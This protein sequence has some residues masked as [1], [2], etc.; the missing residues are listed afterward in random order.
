LEGFLVNNTIDITPSTRVLRM[1]G[2][3]DFAPWQCLAELIDNSIDSFIDQKNNGYFSSNPRVKI[4]LPTENELKQD[5]GVIEVSDNGS[6]MTLTELESSVRA[7]YSGNDPVDKMGLFGMGFNIST[8]RLGRKTEVWTTK[9]DAEEWVGLIIDFD[10]LEKG[11]SFHAPV[12]TKKKS[13][14]EMDT[15]TNGTRIKISRLEKERIR[16]LI[17]GQ[18]KS[19]TKKRLGKI[20]GRVM[21]TLDISISYDGDKIVPGRHCTWDPKRT[22]P[23]EKFGDVPARIDIC[24]DFPDR[25]F[26][27]TCWVWLTESEANCSSCGLKNNIIDRKRTL[28]GWIGVQRYFHKK[29]FGIDLIRNGRV[30]EELDKSLFT[31][32]D[33][34]G[35]EL[36]EYPID[37]IHWG[38]RI[39]GELEIDFV[40]VSHQKDSFDKLDPEWKNIVSRVRGEAPMQPKLAER[41]GYARNTSPLARLFAGYR[42]GKAGLRS[43]VPGDSQGNGVNTGIISEY[44]DKFSDGESEYQGDE[45]WY[46]LVLQ[47]DRAQK[48]PPPD[49]KGPGGDFPLGG[50]DD[51]KE[52]PDLNGDGD[53]K[54]GPDLNGDDDTKEGPDLNGDDGEVITEEDMDLS[55]SYEIDMLPG[56]PKITVTAV[57]HLE[58]EFEEPFRVKP[59]GYRFQFDYYVRHPYF[60]ESLETPEDCLITDL[61]HHFL[62][63]SGESTRQ[64]PISYIA[65]KIREKY[66][67]NSLTDISCAADEAENILNQIRRHYDEFLP[68]EAP[69]D[70]GKIDPP[71][72]SHIRS[73]AL[74]AAQANDEEV[75]KLI[76]EGKFARYV[77]VEYLV[78]LVSIWPSIVTDDSFFTIPYSSISKELREKTLIGI[79]GALDDIRWLAEEGSSSVSKDN[80]WR[81]QYT[82]SLA[83]LRLIESWRS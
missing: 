79:L 74:A 70:I 7:G 4:F 61:A 12:Q 68:E 39:V 26:C 46:E 45:K 3:I 78:T 14:E 55:R 59:D 24:E 47:A 76:K 2:Q 49:P 18:G 17:W 54:E 40:R 19:R 71:Q 73:R 77:Q 81:L 15:G 51:T 33:P 25:R 8:A 52:G 1:L 22:V 5:N 64:F 10:E 36:F 6:G 21:T 30:I 44:F 67:Q 75:D 62:A 72:V 83:S 57:R 29:H 16:P 37:A 43:L 9:T 28:R 27:S 34:N 66:F 11:Q 48:G 13:Q 63:L 53:S 35:D 50:D 69:I 23:A 56:S 31:F 80:T 58:K 32:K 42:K 60:E 41:G 82:R 65:R 20:Y 38:G